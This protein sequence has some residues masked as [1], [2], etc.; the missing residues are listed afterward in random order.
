[1]LFIL[2]ILFMTLAFLSFSSAIF[3]AM[4]R[5]KLK[6]WFPRHQMLNRW[7]LILMVSGFLSVFIYVQVAGAGHFW[8]LHSRLAL[9]A[10]VLLF[11]TAFLKEAQ[12][13]KKLQL[14]NKLHPWMGR[15]AFIFFLLVAAAGILLVLG[16]FY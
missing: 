2:H 12:V 4:K 10:M 9:G 5:T 6:K 1:M 13:R 11:C 16:I 15:L 7:G 8:S 3:I 14:P